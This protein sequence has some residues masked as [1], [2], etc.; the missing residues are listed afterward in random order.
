MLKSMPSD[1]PYTKKL[2]DEILQGQS[3]MSDYDLRYNVGVITRFGTAQDVQTVYRETSYVGS[4][5]HVDQPKTIQWMSDKG[6]EFNLMIN[7]VEMENITS[8]LDWIWRR[9]PH[10]FD[11]RLIMDVIATL[12]NHQDDAAA[13]ALREWVIGHF[14]TALVDWRLSKFRSLPFGEP[15]EWDRWSSKLKT[16][17]QKRK[18]WALLHSA[19][20][21]TPHE[22]TSILSQL[23]VGLRASK[24]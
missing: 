12:F 23:S 10:L 6:F 11:L 7:N 17:M 1:D 20:S 24:L 9:Y 8:Q 5:V 15:T 19:F 2:V 22:L 18:L 21:F 14:D 13:P 3:T 16:D 4:F